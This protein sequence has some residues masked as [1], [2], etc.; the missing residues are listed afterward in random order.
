MS[1]SET[2]I[3]VFVASPSDVLSEREILEDVIAEFNNTWSKQL[4]IRLELIRWE[5]YVYPDIGKDVQD[6]INRQIPDYDIFIGIMW[7]RSG[8]ST[9]R[10]DSGTIEEFAR[11]FDKFQ[12]D[13]QSISIMF[14]FKDHPIPPSQIDPEQLSKVRAFK[15][16][17]GEAGSLYWNFTTTEEFQALV[18][19]HLSR[20]VQ[21]LG[22]RERSK[23]PNSIVKP[24]E[25][26]HSDD[27]PGFL[28]LIDAANVIFDDVHNSVSRLAEVLDNLTSKINYQTKELISLQNTQGQ[29]ETKTARRIASR[30][31]DDMNEY[32]TRTN[33][34]LPIFSRNLRKAIKIFGQ[35]VNISTDF[36][37]SNTEPLYNALRDIS[38]LKS[39]IKLSFDSLKGFG[40]SVSTIPRLTTTLIQ[41]K[42]NTVNTIKALLQEFESSIN[43]I[44]E[45]EKSISQLIEN[46]KQ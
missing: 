18:R 30:V 28:D 20:K 31:A 39:Q 40:D 19:V 44:T 29:I 17:L 1:R 26:E 3:Q 37:P 23:E 36:G 7:A 12:V 11:A 16:M 45:V 9:K 21:E 6:V 10:A 43:L 35:A 25:I 41:A 2:I 5:S 13:S 32:V 22:R 24:N 4:G 46:N 15:N 14:Y 42:R 33:A 34:E 8:T 38:F 27:E